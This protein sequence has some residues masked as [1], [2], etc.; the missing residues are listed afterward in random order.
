LSTSLA[1]ERAMQSLQMIDCCEPS[2]SKLE[3]VN[4][5]NRQLL[6]AD[7]MTTERD[8]FLQKLRRHNRFLHGWGVVCG[9]SVTAS[10]TAGTPWRVQIGSGYALGPY[11]D[12]IFV[13]EAV[14]FDL[15]ACLSGSAT[16][17]CEPG[18]L[19]PGGAGTSTIAYLAIQ[20]A[21]CLA[22]PVQ[23]ANSGC[24]CDNDP[25][26]Y[27]RIRDGFQIQ[28]L[29][30][31]PAAP[32]PGLTLC[33]IVGGAVAPCPPCPTSPWVPLAKIN[34]PSSGAMNITNSRIDAISVRRVV[35]STA[36]LQ[37]QIVSCCCEASSSSSSS[38]SPANTVAAGQRLAFG[39]AVLN[40]GQRA[41]RV[42]DPERLAEGAVQLVVTVANS[43]GR[44]ADDVV[45]T[46][47][48]TP[49]LAASE[50]QL[51]PAPGWETS[52]LAQLRSA[53]VT[54][55]PGKAQ[56]FSFQIRPRDKAEPVRIT[57]K[58]SAATSDAAVAPATSVITATIGG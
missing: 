52:N 42:T 49:Q 4:F 35:L 19:V 58:V 34:L 26:Q 12:E 11:G 13:G 28:C 33:Q 14:Y 5:F 10:P 48:L 50:Y 57:S 16:N 27:S 39:H 38:S 56:S 41:T 53:P 37:A 36:V 3:H 31:L 8:Y 23:V 21:D 43:G 25:C 9:L 30:A 22:R 1:K 44:A 29:A 20:Y 45:L 47:D 24:G 54:I 17:P 32:P 6:T 46:V 2:A 51:A 55:A 18:M 15:A 40:V 7:D